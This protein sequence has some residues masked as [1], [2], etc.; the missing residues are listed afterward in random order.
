MTERVDP[1]QDPAQD[2]ALDLSWEQE[3]ER[4]T[5]FWQRLGLP[6]LL[7][8]HTHFLPE[9]VQRI[10]EASVTGAG[11]TCMPWSSNVTW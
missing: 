4:T 1:A 7:D 8:I 9:P 2:P 5:A 3:V 11:T 10:A 6:G